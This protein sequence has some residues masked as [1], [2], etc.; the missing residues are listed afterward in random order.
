MSTL[1]IF[2]DFN[3]GCY[4]LFE[5]CYA[6][7][8]AGCSMVMSLELLYS[9]KIRWGRGC[10]NNRALYH[11]SIQQRR[12]TPQVSLRLYAMQPSHLLF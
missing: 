6:A 2:G 10:I 4:F 8:P 11:C 12:R 1:V 9:C 5:N 3:V 7:S